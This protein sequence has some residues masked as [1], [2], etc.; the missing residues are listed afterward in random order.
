MRLIHRLPHRRR[1]E[2]AFTMVE[3]ALSIAVVAFAM[4]A[5]L[6]VLPTGLQV[7]KDNREE[8]IINA[9][10]TYILETIRSGFDRAG[11]LDDAIYLVSVNYRNGNRQIFSA[12]NNQPLSSLAVSETWDPQWLVGLLSTPKGLGNQ[13]VSNVVVWARALNNTAIDRDAEARDT[14][15]KYRMVVEVEPTLA[16]PPALTNSLGTNDYRRVVNVQRGLHE[17][18]LTMQWPLFNDLVSQPERAQVGTHRRTFRTQ[19]GGSQRLSQTN[20]LGSNQLLFY[21]Q[22]SLY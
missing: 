10:G 14:A 11:L 16:Y 6:G 15:F 1:G 2:A 22:P 9:D 4:V 21:F 12:P 18:R 8:T 7:Q 5:I 13:G 19:V 3:I 17:I 20:V